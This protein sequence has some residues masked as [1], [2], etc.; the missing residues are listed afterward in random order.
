MNSIWFKKLG[1]LYVP[2][3][4]MG[5]LVSAAIVF[6]NV[7]FFIAIDRQSHSASDTLIHFFVY[8]TCTAFWWKWIAEKTS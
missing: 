1:W 2:V 6:L 8:F 7:I 4:V 3:H 5:L